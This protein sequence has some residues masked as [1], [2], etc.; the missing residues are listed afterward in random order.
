MAI[1]QPRS[2]SNNTNLGTG[3]HLRVSV[4]RNISSVVLPTPVEPMIRVLP[5]NFLSAESSP[6]GLLCRFK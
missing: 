3:F 6:S 4:S 2:K 1:S 5:G